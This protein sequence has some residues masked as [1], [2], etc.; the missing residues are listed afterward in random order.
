MLHGTLEL[1]KCLAAK[2]ILKIWPVLREETEADTSRVPQQPG[3]GRPGRRFSVM[4]C[5]TARYLEGLLE[6]LIGRLLWMDGG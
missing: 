1:G 4:A 3:S 6:R 5:L 2:E